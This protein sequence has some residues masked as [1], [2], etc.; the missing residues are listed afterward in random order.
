MLTQQSHAHMVKKIRS[1]S[2]SKARPAVSTRGGFMAV[3]ESRDKVDL[4]LALAASCVPVEQM[5]DGSP[6]AE[7]RL[8]VLIAGPACGAAVR[9]GSARAVLAK[10][11][12]PTPVQRRGVLVQRFLPNGRTVS[13]AN[14]V[15]ARS[16][17]P[18]LGYLGSRM[19]T[20]IGRSVRS[21]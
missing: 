19:T 15:N 12:R 21:W 1:M 14:T 16:T 13:S 4:P 7:A 18:K 17:R 11:S 5:L 9:C 8:K 6:H 20:G 10:P 3:E 2:V